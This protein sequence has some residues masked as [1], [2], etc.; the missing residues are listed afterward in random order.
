M[1]APL[2][3][4]LQELSLYRASHWRK[5]IVA[6]ITQ[7][8]VI[9]DNLKR[10]V[11]NRTLCSCRLFL[12]TRIFQYISNWLKVFEHLPTLFLQYTQTNNFSKFFQIISFSVGYAVLYINWVNTLFII[13]GTLPTLK[14][15]IKCHPSLRQLLFS[16]VNLVSNYHCRKGEALKSIPYYM[17]DIIYKTLK[18]LHLKKLQITQNIK[19][20][21]FQVTFILPD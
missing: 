4:Q 14:L 16:E 1:V 3:E 2:R 21:M 20:L 6:V 5:N 9:I 17:I 11:K 8:R 18:P 19:N 15:P 12:L 10:Q 13:P 7:D